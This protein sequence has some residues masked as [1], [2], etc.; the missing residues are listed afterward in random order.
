MGS[1]PVAATLLA[2][3]VIISAGL[4]F[5]PPLKH[6]SEFNWQPQ[7]IQ[8][9]GRV[10][11][12]R[13]FPDEIS[14]NFAEL[15]LAQEGLNESLIDFGSWEIVRGPNEVVLASHDSS[16]EEK[17]FSTSCSDCSIT[18]RSS[19][20]GRSTIVVSAIGD[21]DLRKEIVG[22]VALEPR[23]SFLKVSEAGLDAGVSVE[24]TTR[25]FALSPTPLR[26]LI[27]AVSLSLLFFSVLLLPKKRFA[28]R[29]ILRRLLSSPKQLGGADFLVL[30][31]IVTSVMVGPSFSDDQWVIET[32]LHLQGNGV[33]SSVFSP[34]SIWLPTGTLFYSSY[35]VFSTITSNLILL[36]IFPALC[37]LATW[38]IL[39][40]LT[41]ELGQVSNFGVWTK[42]L[43]VS[44]FSSGWLI[45]LR[46]EPFIVLLSALFALSVWNYYKNGTQVHALLAFSSAGV[47]LATHQAGLILLP[48]VIAYAI[49][50][51]FHRMRQGE[52]LKLGMVVGAT[53]TILSTT[54]FA[55]Y[56]FNA[57]FESVLEWR[58]FD[59]H[60]MGPFDEPRRWQNALSDSLESRAVSV[61]VAV[62]LVISAFP[63]VVKLPDP[64]G[65]SSLFLFLSVLGLSLTA[66]KWAWHIGAMLVPAALVLVF[67]LKPSPSGNTGQSPHGTQISSH[68][69]FIS[70]LILGLLATPHRLLFLAGAILAGIAL[71]L[72]RWR[73]PLA[74]RFFG[75]SSQINLLTVVLLQTTLIA[76]LS[77]SGW[78]NVSDFEE[79]GWRVLPNL[80]LDFGF[81]STKIWL[82]T[83][84][85]SA[86]VA[87]TP[88]GTAEGNWIISPDSQIGTPDYLAI[89][90][91]EDLDPGD[92]LVTTNSRGLELVSGSLDHESYPLPENPRHSWRQFVYSLP[93]AN[94]DVIVTPSDSLRTAA[95][96]GGVRIA[97]VEPTLIRD[98]L[99]EKTFY[100]S[101]YEA[102]QYGGLSVLS[103]E[104]GFWAEPDLVV[105]DRGFRDF[106]EPL[107]GSSL[108][109]VGENLDLGASIYQ[110]DVDNPTRF[111]IFQL[112][113][114]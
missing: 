45:T 10:I 20:P 105:A 93:G 89:W 110:I 51:A 57:V 21:D 8:D 25:P 107:S 104:A 12:D 58:A 113:R 67:L 83:D 35:A 11:L 24:G 65:V 81:P 9:S 41:N 90:V 7:T 2:L 86:P 54:T 99:S 92:L 62:A 17:L 27:L 29:G 68:L 84:D 87:S 77:L 114:P 22:E 64:R 5:A 49:L 33:L 97:F 26:A 95:N 69:F 52:W 88:R 39:R 1:I 31:V 82:P 108:F 16:V 91:R 106:S 13:G 4:L 112:I 63:S 72:S 76:S 34:S 78:K 66:S 109:F 98:I 43:F 56:D 96:A 94:G 74:K 30:V 36:R 15:N 46:P 103:S 32:A 73:A 53:F 59:T 100:G 44:L 18:V 48:P 71:L 42:A 6:V 38:F 111:H 37:V 80:Y 23:I 60:S 19:S 55:I 50:W 79:F 28:V 75:V 85:E 101:V 40:H 3:S 47:A 70:L 102:S 61:A 14:I